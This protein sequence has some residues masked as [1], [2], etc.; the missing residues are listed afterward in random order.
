MREKLNAAAENSI[1]WYEA[2]ADKIKLSPYDFAYDYLMR[3]GVMTP[4][5]LDRY[6]P[7]FMRTYRQVRLAA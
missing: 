3:T 1:A 7:R 2:I 4:E 6:S 5:R